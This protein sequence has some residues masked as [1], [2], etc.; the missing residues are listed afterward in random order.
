MKQANHKSNQKMDYKKAD[1]ELYCPPS[2]PV[3]VE[4]PLISFFMVEGQ[5]N[6]NQPQGAYA[7]AL[8]LLYA[9]S[10]TVKMSKMNQMP[11]GYFEYVMPPLESLWWL[12]NGG[13][14]DAQTVQ[15]KDDF[16][17]YAMIRQPEFVTPQLLAW[18]RRQVK[19]KKPHLAVE[20]VVLRTWQEGLCLQLL[21]V[22]PYDAE[23]ASLA[24]MA[25][26]IQQQGLRD[27]LGESLP[28]GSK[29]LHHEI[30]LNDP[31]KTAPE[32]QKTILRWPVRRVE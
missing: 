27:A 14:F 9:F 26:F 5:G 19:E 32:K 23:P 22:G 29:R 28:D 15:A 20:R 4:V 8:E 2:W 11:P 1:K 16:C 12:A 13:S 10:Y 6:P 25:A 30:Y 18:A 17:W 24:K 31:R 7:E 21:H 3:L